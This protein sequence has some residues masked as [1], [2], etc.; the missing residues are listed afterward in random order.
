MI[1]KAYESGNI[2]KDFALLKGN[3]GKDKFYSGRAA[4]LAASANQGHLSGDNANWMKNYPD[5]KLADSI[6]VFNMPASSDGVRY[7][8]TLPGYW[9]ESYISGKVDDTKL[10]RILR[11]YDYMLS[12]DG[13][14]E[15]GYGIKNVDY[16]TNGDVLT[17]IT[18]DI[19]KKYPSIGTVSFL[20][21]WGDTQSTTRKV[22]W[23]SDPSIRNFS[24]SYYDWYD[25]NTKRSPINFDVNSISTPARSKLVIKNQD[26]F[27]KII[28][29]KGDVQAAFDS[30]VSEYK[31]KGLDQA[32][33]EVNDKAKAMGIK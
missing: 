20:A 21:T 24:K 13:M 7:H 10:D 12:D 1:K 6:K 31:A 22:I 26:E 11:V 9:S 15:L 30:I 28:L 27:T 5:K 18:P 8:F 3:E 2:D 14:I 32:I 23:P 25:K 17:V 16:T 33:T 4:A 19:K 29:S